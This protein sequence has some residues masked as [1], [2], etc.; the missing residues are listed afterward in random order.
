MSAPSFTLWKTLPTVSFKLAAAL[1]CSR[2]NWCSEEPTETGTAGVY[3]TKAMQTLIKPLEVPAFPAQDAFLRTQS[4]PLAENWW[5]IF[6]VDVG[7]MQGCRSEITPKE[8][9]LSLTCLRCVKRQW[10]CHV[11]RQPAHLPANPM[12]L[13]EARTRRFPTGAAPHDEWRH[14]ELV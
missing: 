7:Q 9:L 5:Q 4:L 6:A 12:R 8:P 1:L 3:F 10:R 13:A 2:C 11:A 14:A